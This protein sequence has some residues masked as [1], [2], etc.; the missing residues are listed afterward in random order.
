MDLPDFLAVPRPNGSVALRQTAQSICQWLAA[1][2]IPY[3]I[4]TFP[5]CAWYNEALGLWLMGMA[6]LL[7]VAVIGRWGWPALAA[8]VLNVGVGVAEVVFS[9]PL[10]SRLG[11][12]TGENILVTFPAAQAKQEVVLCAHY[13]T[14]TEALDHKRRRLFTANLLPAMIV[15]V[16]TGG[17]G[18]ADAF[19]AT[20]G[21]PL[22]AFTYPLSIALSLG[23]LAFSLGMGL[24][25]VTGRLL[26]RQ[27]RGAVDNGAAC[28][29][30]L[31]LCQRLATGKIEVKDTTVTVAFFAGE[32]VTMQGSRAYVDGRPWP[33]PATAL[34]LECLGQDGDYVI[35]QADGT[36]LTRCPTDPG[37]NAALEAAVRSVTGRQVQIIPFLNSDAYSFLRR[38]IKAS[39]LGSMDRRLGLTGL[40]GPLDHPGR[41][42]AA[43]LEEAVLVLQGF[44]EGARGGEAGW[45][46]SEG[47]RRHLWSCRS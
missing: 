10:V 14:K 19:L 20:G 1:R 30:L 9:W 35:W 7:L 5:L 44:L 12:T 21:S 2:G 6:L 41:V 22:A 24:N 42:T 26:P 25:L 36:V 32:E 8:A 37:I 31:E 16:A 40:H 27:S 39:T 15:C 45:R 28:A 3:Q 38:G 18:W 23:V 13:D 11:Q 34:N 46:V 43:R 29:V 33:L 4:Q 17:L 47:V